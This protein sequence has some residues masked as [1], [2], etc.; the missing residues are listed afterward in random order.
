MLHFWL[1]LAAGGVLLAASMALYF[2]VQGLLVLFERRLNVATWRRPLQHLWTTSC[3]LVTLP[4][5]LEPLL[6]VTVDT[7]R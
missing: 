1:T 7:L 5:L 6:A 3:M 4:L 2:L